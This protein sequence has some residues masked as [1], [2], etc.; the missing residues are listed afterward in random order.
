MTSQISKASKRVSQSATVKVWD[1]FVRVF[2]WTV[3][4]AFFV[5]Y[6][7]EDEVLTLH[8]WAGYTI[9]VLIILRIVW[10]FVG[11][12]HAR[13]SDFLFGPFKTWTYLIDLVL[14]R[15]Q[16]YLG[17]SPAGAAMVFALLIGLSVTVL[18]GLELYA[19]EKHAGPLGYLSGETRQG[20]GQISPSLIN[21]GGGEETEREAGRNDEGAGGVWKELHEAL[22]SAMFALVILHV[23]G[24][25]FASV[26][27]R[28]NLT[29]AMVTGR[30]R[31]Q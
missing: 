16:R 10:G 30:K 18:S 7:T 1:L 14:F 11:P 3:T 22:A 29:R 5:A 25:L 19:A 17:H 8:V 21:V 12:K 13:F 23:G 26:V 2:H 24:V 4:I 6:F 31:A 20:P 28:E 9:G 27:H 15:A